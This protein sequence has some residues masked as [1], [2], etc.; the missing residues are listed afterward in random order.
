M[1]SQ[2][3]KERR[4][5][6]K[7][8]GFLGRNESV[9]QLLERAKRS[10]DF[11]K[12][13]HTMHLEKVMNNQLEKERIKTKLLEEHSIESFNALDHEPVTDYNLES[14]SFLKENTTGPE[15]S[16]SNLEDPQNNG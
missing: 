1:A 7:Q 8:M 2:S 10:S 14:Y 3:R 16:P 13:L 4:S 12:Q 6:A 5:F 11:G 15:A 9:S